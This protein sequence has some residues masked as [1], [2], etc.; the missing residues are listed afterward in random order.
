MNNEKTFPCGNSTGNEG[1]EEDGYA[2]N[3]LHGIS[4]HNG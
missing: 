4:G 1:T 3:V 2:G